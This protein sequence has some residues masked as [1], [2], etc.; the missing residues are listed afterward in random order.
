VLADGVFIGPHS[1]LLNDKLPRAIT[2]DGALKTRAD[3]QARGVTVA[4][5]ASVGGGCTVLPGVRIGRFAMVGAGAVVTRNVPDF[6]LAVGNPARLIGYV[7]ECGARLTAA[8][9]CSACGRQHELRADDTD[10]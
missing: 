8:G 9:A 10:G 4:T 1:C 5:G 6:G 7:C 2:P 3:W